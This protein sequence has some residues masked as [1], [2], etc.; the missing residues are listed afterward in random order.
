M[1]NKIF[2]HD[3]AMLIVEL[4]E[5]VLSDYDIS[6]P[7][8]EDDDRDPE[9]SVGLYGSTYSDLLEAVEDRLLLLLDKHNGLTKVIPYEFS[10]TV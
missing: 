2:T 5:A 1:R 7:S 3:E 4:F 6:V 10:G 9:D 8:P